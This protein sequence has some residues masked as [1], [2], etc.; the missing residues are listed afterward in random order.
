MKCP[1]CQH[2]V[3]KVVDSRPVE[4]GKAIRRR[5]ECS[6][7]GFRFTTFE[8]IEAETIFVVKR[9]G[10]RELFDRD[11]ILSGILR[12]SPKQSLSTETINHV[13]DNVEM[14][15]NSRDQKEIT[16]EAI[17]QMVLSEL[18]KI[19]EVAYIRF[20][21]VYNNFQSIDEFIAAVQTMNHQGEQ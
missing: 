21:S 19:D 20:A 11:K 14:I 4:N 15:V 13:V 6:N 16:S 9:S 18:K 12:S 7:C 5:R 10:E 1:K 8:R 2:N 17:G 3:S